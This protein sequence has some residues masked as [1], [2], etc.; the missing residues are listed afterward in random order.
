MRVMIGLAVATG[1]PWEYWQRQDDEVVATALDI[2]ERARGKGRPTP[3]GGD[4]M[5]RAPLMSG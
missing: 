3:Q 4:T 2:L 5:Q 1:L